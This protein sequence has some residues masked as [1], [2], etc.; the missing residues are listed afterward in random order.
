MPDSEESRRMTNNEL[1]AV[2]NERTKKIDRELEELKEKQKNEFVSRIEFDSHKKV[3]EANR[4][5][6][7]AKIAPIRAIV[8]GMVSVILVAVLTG[9][10]AL[11]VTGGK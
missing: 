4:R 7:E 9:L 2:I 11:V 5:E 8:Y 10:V 3:Q 1:L 6:L